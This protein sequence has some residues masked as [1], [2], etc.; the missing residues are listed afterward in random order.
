MSSPALVFNQ[1]PKLLH[2]RF[3]D[4]SSIGCLVTGSVSPTMVICQFSSCEASKS[5]VICWLA[6][7][8]KMLYSLLMAVLVL[9]GISSRRIL[10]KSWETL[11]AMLQDPNSVLKVAG[12]IECANA[13]HVLLVVRAAAICGIP[14]QLDP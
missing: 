3:S 1:V 8:C 4:T 6:G 5:R 9:G 10:F 14:A 7:I 11:Y 13:H 2:P 12:D